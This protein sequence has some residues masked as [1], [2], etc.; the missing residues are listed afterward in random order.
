M[1]H[2]SLSIN[3]VLRTSNITLLTRIFSCPLYWT[4]SGFKGAAEISL[5]S[6]SCTSVCWLQYP[7]QVGLR[8]SVGKEGTFVIVRVKI[9]AVLRALGAAGRRANCRCAPTPFVPG[10]R[11]LSGVH[12]RNMRRIGSLLTSRNV[13]DNNRQ[14]WSFDPISQNFHFWVVEP[15]A[16]IIVPT[17][18]VH[19]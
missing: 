3:V 5:I 6:P 8:W 1:H 4:G 16:Q 13:L 9:H 19:S 12:P 11:L 10:D 14:A 18:P 7:A 17:K 2:L 15:A